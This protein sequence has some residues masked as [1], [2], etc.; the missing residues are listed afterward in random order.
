MQYHSPDV[1]ILSFVLKS[2]NMT[3]K[4][5]GQEQRQS[6]GTCIEIFNMKIP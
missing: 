1:D 2:D 4:M 6:F 5:G 3:S